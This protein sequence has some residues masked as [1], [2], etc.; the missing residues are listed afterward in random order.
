MDV[1]L[2]VLL[3]E[4]LG[5]L[6]LGRCEGCWRDERQV[7]SWSVVS[8]AVAKVE[9]WPT[10]ARVVGWVVSVCLVS[11]HKLRMLVPLGVVVGRQPQ[12]SLWLNSL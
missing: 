3:Q 8:A 4:V 11:N 9:P 12:L 2:Q 7:R 6:A 1:G 5:G 10:S